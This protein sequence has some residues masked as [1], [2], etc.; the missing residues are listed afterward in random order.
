MATSTRRS[1][2]S[3]R[4]RRRRL[5]SDIYEPPTYLEVGE[6]LEDGMFY[7]ERVISC[8]KKEVS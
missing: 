1:R 7:V 4:K 3:K 8:R 2:R 5:D 6:E